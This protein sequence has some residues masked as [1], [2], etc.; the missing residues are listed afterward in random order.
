[1]WLGTCVI[2]VSPQGLRIKRD[3][4]VAPLKSIE[5][6]IDFEGLD[7]LGFLGSLFLELVEE[8][9]PL[10]SLFCFPYLPISFPLSFI[11][12]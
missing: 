9:D 1:M 3:C 5:V 11:T 8:A 12:V 2:L 4:D 7:L 6:F 10:C